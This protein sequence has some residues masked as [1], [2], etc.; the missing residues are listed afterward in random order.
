M[1]EQLNYKLYLAVSEHIYNQHFGNPFIQSL[2]TK[3][4]I[5]LLICY[6]NTN[7]VVAWKRWFKPSMLT[8]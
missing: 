2:V 5:N 1:A 4:L 8:P 7:T 3:Y 6:M